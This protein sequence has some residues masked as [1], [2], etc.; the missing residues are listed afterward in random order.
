[1]SEQAGEPLAPDLPEGV[2][3]FD[4]DD[5]FGEPPAGDAHPGEFMSNDQRGGEVATEG[6]ER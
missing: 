1:M 2:V 5:F 3:L 4:Q 6:K